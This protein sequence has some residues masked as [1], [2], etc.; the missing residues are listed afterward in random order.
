MINI[1]SM[2]SVEIKPHH[3]EGEIVSIV[4]GKPV[5]FESETRVQ[6]GQPA[7]LVLG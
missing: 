2:V 3:D 4:Y 5:T 1:L 6:Y 7:F